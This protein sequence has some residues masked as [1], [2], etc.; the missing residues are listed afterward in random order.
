[1]VDS[2]QS[3]FEPYIIKIRFTKVVYKISPIDNCN[4]AVMKITI[5]LAIATEAR[6]KMLSKEL[7]DQIIFFKN[8]CIQI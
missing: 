7:A 5:L 1:M 2:K 8:M 6:Q 3:K 4:N